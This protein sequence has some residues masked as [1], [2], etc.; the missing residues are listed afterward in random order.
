MEWEGPSGIVRLTANFERD[1]EEIDRFLVE[2]GAPQAF[3]P[4]L[5]E[6]IDIIIPDLERFPAMGRSFLRHPIRSVEARNGV[7]RLGKKLAQLGEGAEIREYI[8]Q[9]YLVLYVIAGTAIHLLSIRHDKQ[10]SFDFQ[11]LWDAI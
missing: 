6:L 3:D 11:R 7:N 1:L 10:R 9:H 2:S 8:L 5:D 4:L